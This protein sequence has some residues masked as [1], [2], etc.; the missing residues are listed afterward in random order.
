[1]WMEIAPSSCNM[2]HY[3]W[4]YYQKTRKLLYGL[5]FSRIKYFMVLDKISWSSFQ[6]CIASVMS[7]KFHK[8]KF[9]GH[10]LTREIFYLENF[11]LYGSR[12]S[13]NRRIFML[14]TPAKW[15]VFSVIWVPG[16]PMLWAPTAPT[17]VPGSIRARRNLSTHVVMNCSS[18][19]LVTRPTWY[20]TIQHHPNETEI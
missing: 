14:A 5:K 19:V 18:W 1:M 20:S 11:R 2:L 16:S 17:A 4:I 12:S 10:T 3:P 6:P 9:H 8:R 13:G 7:L 15:N